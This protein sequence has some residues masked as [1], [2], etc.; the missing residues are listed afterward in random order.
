MDEALNEEFEE[1]LE[2]VNE[3]LVGVV[4]IVGHVMEIYK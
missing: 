1:E 2:E 4:E 3:I